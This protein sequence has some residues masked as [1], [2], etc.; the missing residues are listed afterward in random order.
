M[1]GKWKTWKISKDRNFDINPGI[2]TSPGF[3]WAN[4][5]LCQNVKMLRQISYNENRPNYCHHYIQVQHACKIEF[6]LLAFM[7]RAHGDKHYMLIN[8]MTRLMHAN[9]RLVCMNTTLSTLG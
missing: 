5:S 2:L 9:T 7:Y 3:D 4:D 8:M 1:T 6:K